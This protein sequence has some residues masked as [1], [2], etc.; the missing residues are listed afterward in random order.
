M[1]K[2]KDSHGVRAVPGGKPKLV[3]TFFFFFFFFF[4]G[5]RGG[6]VVLKK[7]VYLSSLNH[8]SLLCTF[9]IIQK[10]KGCWKQ[11]SK[12]REGRFD[13]SHPLIKPTVAS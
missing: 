9:S 13:L 7:A 1:E 6:G 2:G 12:P 3:P 4:G 11:V 10:K 8:R 5:G